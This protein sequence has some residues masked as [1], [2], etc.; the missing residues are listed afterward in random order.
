LRAIRAFDKPAHGKP[1]ALQVPRCHDPRFSH[2]LTPL[3]TLRCPPNIVP[4][5]KPGSNPIARSSAE[6]APAP[7]SCRASAN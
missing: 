2:S 1:P 3:P 5:C 4:K 7:S 6:N